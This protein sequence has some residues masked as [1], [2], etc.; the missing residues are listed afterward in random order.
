MITLVF[1][2]AGVLLL[3]EHALAAT[4]HAASMREVLDGTTPRPALWLV[5]D[6][7]VFLM[8]NG[9]VTPVDADHTTGLPVVH[10]AGYTTHAD[11][12]AVADEIGRGK[13]IRIILPLLDLTFGERILH[14]DL[15]GGA[16]AG[17]ANFVIELDARHL[18]W[19]LPAAG[20]TEAKR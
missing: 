13:Q 4:S 20:I 8:S 1:P 6:Q 15:T 9:L 12:L 11:W 18:R 7:G 3:A 17:A 19:H 10:A 2:L 14:R 16:D 5:G